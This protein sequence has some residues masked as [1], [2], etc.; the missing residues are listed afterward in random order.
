M[1]G[2]MRLFGVVCGL[3][4]S[5]RTTLAAVLRHRYQFP[6]KR[7]S[8][9]QLPKIAAVDDLIRLAFS[10]T[11]VIIP[12]RDEREYGATCDDYGT[13]RD[14]K[15]GLE[16]IGTRLRASLGTTHGNERAQ[17]P[18]QS[19]TLRFFTCRLTECFTPE[20]AGPA[21]GSQQRPLTL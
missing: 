15:S 9:K 17:G 12:R 19:S 6:V 1:S 21:F 18:N 8:N 4:D 13:W 2:S 3:L 5:P 16:V 20:M 10:S 14:S 11:P 7:Q